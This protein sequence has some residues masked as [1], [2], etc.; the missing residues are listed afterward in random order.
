[1]S[2]QEVYKVSRI[3]GTTGEFE[4]EIQLHLRGMEKLFALLNTAFVKKENI[5]F[6]EEDEALYE[7]KIYVSGGLSPEEV[8]NLRLNFCEIEPSATM[9]ADYPEAV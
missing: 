8:D 4:S 1:M 7:M 6:C 9:R 5:P 2:T 3:C